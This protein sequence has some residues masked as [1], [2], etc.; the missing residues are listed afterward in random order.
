MPSAG[1]NASHEGGLV[2]VPISHPSESAAWKQKVRSHA[3]KHTQAR[4]QRVIAYQ[5]TVIRSRSLSDGQES[6]GALPCSSHQ[7]LKALEV[8]SRKDCSELNYASPLLNS[9][10]SLLGAARTDPFNSYHRVV[11]PWENQLLDHFLQYLVL[12][13]M[14][15]VPSLDLDILGDKGSFWKSMASYWVHTALSDPGMLAN[16]LLWS[17]RHMSAVQHREIYDLQATKYRFE[18]I[19][20]LNQTLTKEGKNI[21]NLTITKTLALASDSNLTGEHDVAVKHLRAVG[22]MIR[23]QDAGQE[24]SDFLG[25]LI[26]WFT[27]DRSAKNVIGSANLSF[28]TEMTPIAK[29]DKS[30]VYHVNASVD[31]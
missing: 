22:H 30:L 3:A 14:T 20:L 8:V 17:C 24:P 2:F 25:R 13:E 26:I 7:P 29:V 28:G 19:R 15:C 23:L 11:T 18:C 4:R 12:Q 6:E 16:T 31:A 9:P 10:V 5:Q 21:S 1:K 27:T